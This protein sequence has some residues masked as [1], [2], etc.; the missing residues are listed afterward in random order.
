MTIDDATARAMAL[1]EKELDAFLFA[2]DAHGDQ[3][4]GEGRPYAAHLVEAHA[5]AHD[6][7]LP[8][9]IRVAALL[10]DVL[11]D[12]PVSFE[13][14]SDRFGRPVA[15]LVEAVTGRGKNRKARNENA[16]QKIEW[17][18]PAAVLLKL[19]DRIANVEAARAGNGASYLDLYRREQEAFAPRMTQ[20]FEGA[21]SG[22]TNDEAETFD[23]MMARLREALA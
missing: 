10:H 20:A 12:T 18:A 14:L 17:E 6:F 8:E 11:E 7:E 23:R 13:T 5:I 21:R 15:L 19:C 16:Y 4:H 1:T 22:A 3:T 2:R 9:T